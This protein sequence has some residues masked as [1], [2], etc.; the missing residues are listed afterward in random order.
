M[1]QTLPRDF[2]AR[3]TLLV[4]RE[5]LGQ[6]LV[7]HWEG[8]RLAGRIVE[9]EAYIGM[10]DLASHARFGKTKRSAAM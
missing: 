10:D 4:A 5:L 8:Q 2:F 7:R 1:P 9:V 3:P 6:R